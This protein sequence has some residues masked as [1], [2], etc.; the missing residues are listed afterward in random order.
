MKTTK[1]AKKAKDSAG[2]AGAS[3]GCH[4]HGVT[5]ESLVMEALYDFEAGTMPEAE[6]AA[7][8]RHLAACPPCVRF[9]DSYRATGRTLR[10][11]KPREIPASLAKT[12][13]EFV[14]ARCEK[15]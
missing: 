5:C 1:K 12:V 11:L 7:L 9:L 2:S 13:F 3:G 15:K 8:E 14:K 10:A 4:G 6:R